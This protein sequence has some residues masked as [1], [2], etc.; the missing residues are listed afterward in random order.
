MM[1]DYGFRKLKS[2]A[3][4]MIALAAV[5][6]AISHP[7]GYYWNALQAKL[8]GIELTAS[9]VP[10][11]GDSALGTGI[12]ILL[13]GSVAILAFVTSPYHTH[14]WRRLIL[15]VPLS[16]YI[17]SAYV[18]YEKISPIDEKFKD[19]YESFEY[20]IFVP[21]A[22][23]AV[24]TAVYLA[25]VITLPS[26]RVT[27][28]FGW[29]VSVV[30]I[31][32]YLG[33]AVFII[34][35]HTMTIL[36]GKFGESEFYMYLAAFALDVVSFF[37]ML[38]VLMTYC[39]I[40]REERWDRLESFAM[41]AEL[42]AEEAES[43]ARYEPPAPSA[44]LNERVI[45]DIEDLKEHEV[46]LSEDYERFRYAAAAGG[47]VETKDAA[48]G[49]TTGEKGAETVTADRSGRNIPGNENGGGRILEKRRG[50][51]RRPHP[52]KE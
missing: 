16:V 32:S 26:L 39:M 50:Q 12:Y 37:F 14:I 31:L 45:P 24:V 40:K 9:G 28:G 19:L 46:T 20:G 43:Y 44:H 5:H 13:F 11:A 3:L 48:D 25:L 41:E 49:A 30:A 10:E 6:I 47:D 52:A 1:D 51:R 35:N 27:Q 23:I 33:S 7:L 8:S 42:E 2:S 29:V 15:I 22:A 17:L 18:E 36:D 4:V 21:Y 38:S 34:Y